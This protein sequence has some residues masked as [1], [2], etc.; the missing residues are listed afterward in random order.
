MSRRPFG[1]MRK[2][3]N[4]K[5]QARYRDAEGRDHYAVFD[6]R[7]EAR[8]HLAKAEADLIRGDWYD[9]REGT[10]TVGTWADDWLATKRNLAY[11]TRDGY[12][13]AIRNQIKPMLGGMPLTRLTPERV[14]RW[15]A[16]MEA[17]GCTPSVT[18]R[19]FKVLNLMMKLAT[20]RRY[21]RAN[22][23]EPVEAPTVV[24]RPQLFLTPEEVGLVAQEMGRRLPQY[25]T[26]VL[27][28][29]YGG[30]RWG[31]CAGLYVS[32][33]DLLRRRVRVKRQLHPNGTLTSPK[34]EAGT[35]WVDIP[36]WLCDELARTVSGRRPAV[37]L[38]EEHAELLFLSEQ[39]PTPAPVELHSALL[40]IGGD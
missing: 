22:P 28:A 16:D 3:T 9:P 21:V 25:Q 34:T 14:E 40:A 33:L 18:Q 15:V 4:G 6:T 1:S 36:P 2:K 31:E 30:L 7:V 12:L 19:A 29:A 37:G 8:Q 17:D 5:Y 11:R 26:M 13:V 39:G 32:D 35:R 24:V 38:P 20:Q 27:L 23:C 10:T